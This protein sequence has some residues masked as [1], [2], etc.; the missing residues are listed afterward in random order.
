V[1]KLAEAERSL[2]RAYDEK[3]CDKYDGVPEKGSHELW[4]VL[5]SVPFHWKPMQLW[6]KVS[7]R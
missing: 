5:S 4:Q 1:R 7:G 6:E 3:R 2:D